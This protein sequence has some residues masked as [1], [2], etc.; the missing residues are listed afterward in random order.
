MKCTTTKG[1]CRGSWKLIAVAILAAGAGLLIA[2]KSDTRFGESFGAWLPILFAT[3]AG[4]FAASG[5]GRCG[6][7]RRA[8]AKP[9]AIDAGKDDLTDWPSG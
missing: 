9:E 5:R 7:S 1:V 8:A 4:T 3:L 6:R 2:L